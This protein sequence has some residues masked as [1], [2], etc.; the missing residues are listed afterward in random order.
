MPSKL[1]WSM[2]IL[3]PL[4]LT[5]LSS[6]LLRA[7]DN[8]EPEPHHS[9]KH[10]S[11][12]V[13]FLLYLFLDSSL[14]HFFHLWLL[15]P[16]RYLACHLPGAVVPPRSKRPEEEILWS[17]QEEETNDSTL[18][19][20]RQSDLTNT[21]P[22]DWIVVTP[23]NSCNALQHLH[24]QRQTKRK[25]QTVKNGDKACI[26]TKPPLQTNSQSD[27][28]LTHIVRPYY[29]NH[30]RG[31][32]RLR[33]ASQRVGA[34]LGTILASFLLCSFTTT[35][36]RLEDDVGLTLHPSMWLDLARGFFVGSFIVTFIF[37]L[38]L[39]LGWVRIIGYFDTV[40]PNENFL[41]NFTWDILFHI[42]V[43]INEEVMM[44]GWM[45]VLGS[46][47]IGTSSAEWFVDERT[48]ATFAII[49]AILLQST[50]FAMLHYHSPGSNWVSLMNLFVGG[51]AASFNFMVAGGT[52][53]L[54]IGW[55]FGWNIFMG[56]VL[57]RSTS[58]IP[59]SCA[60]LNVVPR[61]C[62]NGNSYERYHGGMFGPE[63][64]VLAPLA[65]VMGTCMM[66]YM[67]GLD[68]LWDYRDGLALQIAK[69]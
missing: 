7:D 66:I 1:E 8:T 27:E 47:C 64:G 62:W 33:H 34:A 65:Y 67:Y 46:R 17:R 69:R 50:F 20:P 31:S 61:P 28:S 56:H 24:D 44:R 11:Y 63:Q 39:G 25:G 32:T 3:I 36:I 53:W 41:I 6:Y 52:L 51:I 35:W 16:A 49:M 42:G 13:L 2:A 55:H 10:A 60:V 68:G 43:S 58:G 40:D 37:L 30:V 26:G 38:E 5:W 18:S 45:F 12:T 15:I 23:T 57:G 14:G 21:L 19:W 59:M 29:L 54:G 9:T 48:A 4:Q 22:R